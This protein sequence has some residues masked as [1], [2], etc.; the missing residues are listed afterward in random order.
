M[1]V[2]VTVPGP[3]VPIVW[4]RF[5]EP[6][7]PGAVI[8]QEVGYCL[9]SLPDALVQVTEQAPLTAALTGC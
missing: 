4:L 5:T 2:R 8:L 1:Q 6:E 7:Y 9:G 3:L